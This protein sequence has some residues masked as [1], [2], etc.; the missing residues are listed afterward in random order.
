MAPN[1]NSANTTCYMW[2]ATLT[3]PSTIQGNKL[4]DGIGKEILS[5]FDA[6]QSSSMAMQRECF[7]H[8]SH[9]FQVRPQQRALCHPRPFPSALRRAVLI[10][11]SLCPRAADTVRP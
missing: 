7:K 4:P 8:I 5:N 6:S 2:H 1:H 3:T 9:R 11:H 10:A